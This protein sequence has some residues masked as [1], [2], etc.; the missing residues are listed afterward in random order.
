MVTDVNFRTKEKGWR[1]GLLRARKGD[2]TSNLK[3][4]LDNNEYYNSFLHG[5]FHRPSCY[6]CQFKC[7]HQGYYS[8]LTIADFWK[9][10]NKIPLKVPDYTKGISAVIVNTEKGKHYFESCAEN[11]PS[12]EVCVQNISLRTTMKHSNISGAIRGVKL[13][14]NTFLYH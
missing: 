14:I 5:Y 7:N 1:C 13:R 4:A 11:L 2:K 10:G 8:D 3:R 6:D 9:I 12:M